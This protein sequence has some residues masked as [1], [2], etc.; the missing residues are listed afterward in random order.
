MNKFMLPLV[1]MNLLL[2]MVYTKDVLEKPV[3]K[4]KDLIKNILLPYSFYISID[5]LRLLW[6]I[7]LY[8]LCMNCIIIWSW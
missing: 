3:A 6:K 4:I 1:Y 8:L 2:V 5:K 7:H